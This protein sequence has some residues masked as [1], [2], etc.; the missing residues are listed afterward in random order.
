MIDRT[1]KNWDNEISDEEIFN[2]EFST[3]YLIQTNQHLP[4]F[5]QLKDLVLSTYKVIARFEYLGYNGNTIYANGQKLVYRKS[6]FS[7]L[8]VGSGVKVIEH[9][10]STEGGG[11]NNY[12]SVSRE[13]GFIV[14]EFTSYG[15]P[16][17]N[18]TSG[19]SIN[20]ISIEKI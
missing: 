19:W 13:S 11:S 1:N 3:A 4:I 5:R 15:L 9:N 12:P 16:F 10:L 8:I 7:K 18:K 20:I 17:V 6:K 2:R 14:L